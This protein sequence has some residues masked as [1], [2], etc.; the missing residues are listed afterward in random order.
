MFEH[1]F[2]APPAARDDN[3]DVWW[4]KLDRQLRDLARRRAELD[5]TEIVLLN[6]AVAANLHRKF[7]CMS[8]LEYLEDVLG[9]A[10]RTATER[11]RV[12]KHLRSLPETTAALGR[13]ELPFSAARELSRVA[14]GETEAA[15]LAATAGKSLREIEKLVTGHKR[16]ALPTDPPGDDLREREVRLVLSP[17]AFVKWRELRKD[18]DEELG[19]TLTDDDLVD[20]LD[21][22][23][24]ADGSAPSTR[25]THQI[26]TTICEQCER[27]WQDGAGA[28]VEIGAAAIALAR[29]DAEHLGSLHADV[30]ARATS[31]ITP[32]V[33]RI[34]HRRDHGAC[35]TPWCR[36]K[37]FLDLHHIT[38]R[39][40]GGSHTPTN[41]ISQC[42]RCHRRVHQGLLRISGTAPDALV[43]ER[44]PFRS[45]PV[46][47]RPVLGLSDL[48]DIRAHVGRI[49]ESDP[50]LARTPSGT[51]APQA[52]AAILPPG[53]VQSRRLGEPHVLARHVNRGPDRTGTAGADVGA[54]ITSV[55][56]VFPSQAKAA[57][58]SL[59]WKPAIAC[60]A[61]DGACADLTTP[62]LEALI[63]EAL[64][65]CPKPLVG[66]P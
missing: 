63:R 25:P 26:A 37:K 19:E 28:V 27:G 45:D 33:R 57:L 34:V 21:R 15:W 51:S 36:S 56:S 44:F 40:A 10:P 12:A 62:T 58:V 43:F 13:G 52:T 20:A 30:P 23:G 29:C 1:K 32:S 22:R 66:A 14:T 6:A 5:A 60:A 9:Y 46:D 38:P 7:D 8:M 53:R 16:G 24:R 3:A 17:D 50:A 55:S 31:D 39:A 65:R 35:A 47:D 59:G 11:L 54:T 2:Q 18:L 64:R 4:R 42:G 49:S 41:L 48:D 61:V